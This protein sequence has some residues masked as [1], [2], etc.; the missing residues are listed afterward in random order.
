MFA[1]IGASHGMTILTGPRI[2]FAWGDWALRCPCRIITNR[3][4]FFKNPL[5]NRI[6]KTAIAITIAMKH[7][8]GKTDER[9]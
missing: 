5:T 4:D 7:R 3:N 9:F 6:L 8:A 1:P 2:P